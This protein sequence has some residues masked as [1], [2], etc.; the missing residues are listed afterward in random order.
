MVIIKEVRLKFPS[1]VTAN[2]HSFHSIY[3]RY[4]LHPILAMQIP[5]L[6][7]NLFF[8][9]IFTVSPNK[10]SILIAFKPQPFR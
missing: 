10:I 2:R 1:L 7:I 8:D 9:H 3:L 4:Y 5:N 6:M